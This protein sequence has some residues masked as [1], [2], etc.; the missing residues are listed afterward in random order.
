MRP[1]ECNYSGQAL[2]L[3]NE[4]NI[5]LILSTYQAGKVI[6]LSSDG[7]R[8]HQL[9]RDFTRP[10]GIAL[11]DQMMALA[12]A[13]G[14]T[15]L[16]TDPDLAKTY[17]EKPD[18]YDAFYYPTMM[19]RTDYVDI[20]DIAF[21]RQGL[22]G[23]N[24]SC[25]KFQAKWINIWLI[26]NGFLVEYIDN[27]NR[28]HKKATLEGQQIGL[29]STL[30]RS[31]TYGAYTVTILTEP[32]QRFII[33]NLDKITSESRLPEN[34]NTAEYHGDP[35]TSNHDEILMDLYNKKVSIYEIAVLLKR[36]EDSIKARLKKLGI[37]VYHGDPR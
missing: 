12:G 29:K 5:S 31:S 33:N 24:T 15:V 26:R 36:T 27:E 16:R 28:K 21:T 18:T 35:W 30:R 14:V 23:V 1:F 34:N 8:M 20:H 32:A 25:K 13:L 3:L 2:R 17:P 19:I 37:N 11:K 22:V 6:I 4:L 9:V 10:M 7:S